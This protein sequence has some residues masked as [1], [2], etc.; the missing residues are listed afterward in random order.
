MNEMHRKTIMQD[1]NTLLEHFSGLPYQEQKQ[2]TIEVILPVLKDNIEK[3]DWN[4][5]PA[6]FLQKF[7]FIIF[8][9][10]RQLQI[11]SLNKIFTT[12]LTS[13]NP[14]PANT[15]MLGQP[16]SWSNFTL[17]ENL[18]RDKFIHNSIIRLMLFKH[19]VNVK[20]IGGRSVSMNVEN[21]NETAFYLVAR[22]LF[23]RQHTEKQKLQYSIKFYLLLKYCF[24]NNIDVNL[25]LNASSN[26]DHLSTVAI[27]HRH[28]EDWINNQQ[29]RDMINNFPVFAS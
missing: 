4:T 15:M 20:H 16:C 12:I 6:R 18:I 9:V 2:Y 19:H 28:R 25:E 24:K 13:L 11:I 21:W 27:V 22:E 7:F 23:Y 10:K 8:R 17:L 5:V 1:I 14:S 26:F 29:L 3:I